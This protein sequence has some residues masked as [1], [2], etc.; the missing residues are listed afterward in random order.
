[1]VLTGHLYVGI[2]DTMIKQNLDNYVYRLFVFNKLKL[3]LAC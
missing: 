1:M 3:Q 2:I